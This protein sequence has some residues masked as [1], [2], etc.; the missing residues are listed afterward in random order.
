MGPFKGQTGRPLYTPAERVRR[1]ATVW[2]LVQGILA[3]LQFFVFLVSLALVLRTLATGEGEAAANA[4]VVIKT[5]VLYAIMVTG[6][7]WEKV[8]FGRYLFAPAFYWEDMVSM[9]VL[10]LHT[11]YLAALLTGRLDTTGLMLLALAAYA[12]YAINAT[13]FL[14]KLR[15]A[16]LQAPSD[17]SSFAEAAR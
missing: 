8:V 1:D 4:S 12:T 11:A 14:L 16:R 3:P 5:V 7:I 6:A 17:L 2:T 15:A 13:Q 10:A 9:A